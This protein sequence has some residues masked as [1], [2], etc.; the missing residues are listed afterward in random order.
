MVENPESSKTEV[1]AIDPEG[2]NYGLLAARAAGL[3]AAG[4][5]VALPTETVYGLAADA[6]NQEAVAQVFAVKER[7]TFDPLIVHVR[8]E[9]QLREVAE[10]PPEVE[11]ALVLL[12]SEFWP[13]PLTFLLPKKPIIPDL[14]TAGLPT[15]AVRAPSH[16]VMRRVLKELGRP[17]AAPSA[18]RFGRISPTSAPHV[19]EELGGRLPL[20][21]DAGACSHGL[22][23]TII[24]LEPGPKTKPLARIL[25][26]GPVTPEDLKRFCK[27]ELPRKRSGSGEAALAPGQ[28]ASHY[29]P[30]TPLRLVE[31]PE[32]FQPE[33]G[34]RYGLLSYKGDPKAGLLDKTDWALV[35]ELSPTVGKL[36]EAAVRFFFVLRQLDAAGLDEIIAEPIVEKGLGVAMM[37]R[38]RRA[39]LNH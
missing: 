11:E 24:Q 8:H 21:L 35:S 33:P 30:R 16:P 3:L 7:P 1:A 28:L 27:V 34:K 18:N 37:D 17:I 12:L 39:S 15:V 29:A 14:V 38:L 36:A 19:L 4:E 5:L 9:A 31:T 20:I 25:R 6:L 22:E 2:E 26:A 13:G 32:E 23:S 10:V